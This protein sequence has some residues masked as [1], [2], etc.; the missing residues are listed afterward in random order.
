M[1]HLKIIHVTCALLT[2]LSFTVR[3][4]WM[5]QDSMYLKIRFT[6]I[7]PHVIDTL[8]LLSAIVMLIQFHISVI[9]QPWLLAKITALILYIVLG[10]MAFRFARTKIQKITSWFAALVVLACIF[11]FALT[12]RVIFW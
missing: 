4:I 12:K 5:M 11:A 3:G 2:A 8:L 9:E 7:A 1:D 10:M 6:R